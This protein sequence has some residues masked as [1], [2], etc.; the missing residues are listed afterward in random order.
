MKNRMWN[1]RAVPIAVCRLALG[2]EALGRLA[3]GRAAVCRPTLCRVPIGASLVVLVMLG[4]APAARPAGDPPL[5]PAPVASTLFE[6][7]GGEGVLRPVV[8]RVID[9][10][11]NDPRSRHHF[12]GIRLPYLKDS[13][14][15]FICRQS[16]GGC[17]YDGETMQRTHA[18]L[19][20]RASEFDTLVQTMREELDRAG[21]AEGAKNEL[22]KRLAPFKR[23]IA[24][25][26]PQPTSPVAPQ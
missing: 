12:E 7:L 4:L 26:K 3:L 8:A 13:I 11:A 19:G 20:V 1:V 16:G 25:G 23:D 2:R 10:T 18:H 6:R 15:K 9:R 14:Y 21:V 5:A 22:L 24:G 17:D